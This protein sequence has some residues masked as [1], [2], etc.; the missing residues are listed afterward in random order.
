MNSRKYNIVCFG[1]SNTHGYNADTGGRFSYSERWPG[2]LSSLL[3]ESYSI[4]EEG[5]NGRTTAFDE[6]GFRS[7]NGLRALTP[8]LERVR[9]VDLLILMLGTNDTQTWAASSADEIVKGMDKLIITASC[10]PV[11]WR[12]MPQILVIAPPA[13]D[14]THA[15]FQYSS[16]ND[17]SAAMSEELAAL[18][19]NLAQKRHCHF[20]DAGSV[21]GMTMSSYD[22]IHLTKGSHE[23]L[24]HAL[25]KEIRRISGESAS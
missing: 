7:R 12:S 1:D 13:I 20:F 11:V 14:L 6:P 5:L 19:E 24:A 16:V 8:I 23:L 17:A 4:I 3:G 2:I 18:Y 15:S 25:E 22:G 10:L 9:P 21:P